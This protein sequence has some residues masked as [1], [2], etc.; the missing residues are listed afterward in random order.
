M[1]VEFNDSEIKIMK[2]AIEQWGLNAQAGQTVEE[3]AEL[4]VALQKHINRTPNAD[5]LDNILD[6]IADVEMMLAQMRVALNIG[7]GVLRSR[8]EIKFEKLR[9]YLADGETRYKIELAEAGTKGELLQLY[10]SVTGLPGCTWNEHYPNEE[11]IGRD[12]E[13]KNVYCLRDANG[14]LI[15]AASVCRYGEGGLNDADCYTK[16]EKW[17]EFARIAVSRDFQN[18]GFAKIL[19]GEIIIGLKSQGFK[20]VRLLVSEANITAVSLYKKLGFKKCGAVYMYERDWDC[21][22]LLLDWLAD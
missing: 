4:I 1:K 6:E 10:R 14:E 17:A 18:K 11:I 16:A 20:S 3:C 12:I 19:L 21:Y 22:E 9:R 13:E 15:A 7:D 5:T 8:I 2:T